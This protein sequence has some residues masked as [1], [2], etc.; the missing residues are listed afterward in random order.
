MS[1]I[2]QGLVAHEYFAKYPGRFFSMH[3]QDVDLSATPGVQVPIGKGSI[4]W[5]KTFAT[6]KAGGV[7]NYFVEQTMELTRE[8][9][10]A[11]KAMK[12]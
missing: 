12:A 7:K 3:L 6:A 8:S 10:A 2:S 5:V 11:L 1:T 4:D 9:I